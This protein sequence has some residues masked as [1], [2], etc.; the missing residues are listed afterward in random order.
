MGCHTWFKRPVTEE[1]LAVFKSYAIEDAYNL[2]GDTEENKEF[3]SVDMDRYLK[4]KESVEDNTDYWWKEGYG[5]RITE[6]N[7]EKSEYVCLI[8]GVLYLD[9]ARPV[10]PI[11]EH[12]KRYHDVFRVS[13]Y[14][15]KVIHS[16]RELRR[17]MKK[18]YFELED[19]Q[20]EKISEF[21]RENPGGIITFG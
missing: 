9:L 2:W 8:N 18:K 12:L 6:D 16:R 19:W 10:Y 15:S 1:E 4:A 5:A 7:K 17:W 21:F 20:L 11:F 13:N 3:N 14:P